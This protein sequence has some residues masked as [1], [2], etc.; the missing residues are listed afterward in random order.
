MP[1]GRLDGGLHQPGQELLGSR[2]LG[3]ALTESRQ[4]VSMSAEALQRHA[5][6]RSEK[7]KSKDGILCT[8]LE[9]KVHE[10]YTGCLKIGL[11]YFTQSML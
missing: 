9:K 7:K 1:Q 4:S 10:I 11:R 3:Q 8:A 6:P 5:L 2:V